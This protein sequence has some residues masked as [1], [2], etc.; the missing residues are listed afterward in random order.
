MPTAMEQRLDRLVHE[1]NKI[2]KEMILQKVQPPVRSTKKISAWKLLGEK[3]SV[4]WDHVSA[5]DEIR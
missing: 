3:I 4:R 5:A 2:K 1:L